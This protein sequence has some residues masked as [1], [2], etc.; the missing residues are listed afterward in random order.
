MENNYQQ[1]KEIGLDDFQAEILSKRV[2]FYPDWI[3]PKIN[4][5]QN[6]NQI[7]EAISASK[8]IIQAIKHNQKILLYTDY[9]CDGCCSMAILKQMLK[10][11]GY[12]QNIITIL[13]NK[14]IGYGITTDIT[15]QILQYKPDLVI[16]ADC[17]IS[18]YYN[19]YTIQQHNIDIIITDHH[20][21]PETLPNCYIVN[22]HLFDYDKNICGAG[23]AFML[24]IC[25]ANEL[26]LDIQ[27]KIKLLEYLDYVA[28]ATIADMV[29]MDS[30]TNR[31][32]VIQGLKYINQKKRACWETFQDN[33][34]EEFISFQL[35]PKINSDSRINHIPHHAINY[36]LA[37]EI[38]DAFY[39]FDLLT[40][41]NN[42][43]KK[44]ELEMMQYIEYE[45]NAIV[46]YNSNNNAGIQGIVAGKLMYKYNIPVVLFGN[47]DNPDIIVGACRSNTVHLRDILQEINILYPN[48]I[49]NYGG[50]KSAAGLSI[51]K[52]EFNNFKAIFKDIVNKTPIEKIDIIIDDINKID[53]ETYS[54]IQ[55]LKP[56]G[57][58]YS[59][60]VFKLYFTISKIKILKEEHLSCYLDNYKAIWFNYNK[61]LN[62]QDKQR[63]QALF[64][65]NLNTYNGKSN[66]QLMIQ[67]ILI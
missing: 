46:N 10:Q 16:T 35:A 60:P 24:M 51:Y 41:Y 53:M 1:Y 13:G 61:E 62:L 14:S 7:P 58:N 34:D 12:N 25:V 59:N 47:S 36:L 67:D 3:N 15:N 49:V 17:G 39:E 50:H 52:K 23:V 48:I 9:D 28:I 31:F 45:P 55:A 20:L 27:S 44:L 2:K 26:D 30:I 63:L 57:I 40:Q 33:I 38:D 66:L 18:D 42:D 21:P 65:L 5:I 54:K 19:I 4:S 56:F 8:R 29:N 11:L 43:R 6:F 22:P 64:T 37:T 32:F